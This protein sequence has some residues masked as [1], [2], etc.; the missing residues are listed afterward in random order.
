MPPRFRGWRALCSLTVP[1]FSAD[2]SLWTFVLC[3][4]EFTELAEK[5]E[6]VSRLLARACLPLPG[7]CQLRMGPRLAM[8]G[9]AC[10]PFPRLV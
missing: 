3:D 7:S 4:L 2:S 5:E 10:Q 9:L 1:C 8:A 6:A